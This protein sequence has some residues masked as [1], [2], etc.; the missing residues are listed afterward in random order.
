MPLLNYN[1][2]PEN[3]KAFINVLPKLIPIT[4]NKIYL[5]NNSIKD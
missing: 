1:I 3:A 2:N 4:L 5:I